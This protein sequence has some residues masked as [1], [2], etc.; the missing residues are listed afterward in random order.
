MAKKMMI[1]QCGVPRAALRICKEQARFTLNTQHARERWLAGGLTIRKRGRHES[2]AMRVTK[3]AHIQ[4]RRHRNPSELSIGGVSCLAGKRQ[5]RAGEPCTPTKQ[6]STVPHSTSTAS[7]FTSVCSLRTSQTT[8]SH[9][10]DSVQCAPKKSWSEFAQCTPG[11]RAAARVSRHI[12]Q[13]MALS[14]I[15]ET[16][17]SG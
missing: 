12:R 15:V 17:A 10:T 1:V 8:R 13:E 11:S 4:I 6:V 9:S 3:P 2:I 16:S 5:H 14:I 7:Q